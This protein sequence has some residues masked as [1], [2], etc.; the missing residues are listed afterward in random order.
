MWSRKLMIRLMMLAVHEENLDLQWQ[1]RRLPDPHEELDVKTSTALVQGLSVLVSWRR[2]SDSES[3][4]HLSECF[5]VQEVQDQEGTWPDQTMTLMWSSTRVRMFEASTRLIIP[6]DSHMMDW[7]LFPQ[8]GQ[9]GLV[10]PLG[11]NMMKLVWGS[12][13]GPPQ[14]LLGEQEPAGKRRGGPGIKSAGTSLTMRTL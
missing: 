2:T 5:S 4:E 10:S 7:F 11:T 6:C 9:V 14:Q 13:C 12:G 3:H 8:W 1:Q